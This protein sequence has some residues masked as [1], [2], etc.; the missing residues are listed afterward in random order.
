MR[1]GYVFKI[2]DF[3]IEVPENVL[4]VMKS[5]NESED[6]LILIFS[7]LSAENCER[8]IPPFF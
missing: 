4:K 8:N 1:V 2:P 6:S 5:I 7:D 3:K